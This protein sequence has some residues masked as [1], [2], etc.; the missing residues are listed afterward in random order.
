M[1]VTDMRGNPE[2]M[3]RH[4]EA[5]EEIVEFNTS[6][7]AAYYAKKALAQAYDF[8]QTAAAGFTAGYVF[9]GG[10]IDAALQYTEYAAVFWVGYKALIE[11]PL[12]LKSKE[13]SK[14]MLSELEKEAFKARLLKS[15]G[16]F[17]K[18]DAKN[19]ISEEHSPANETNQ[20]S[21]DTKNSYWA[22][23]ETAK[24][25]LYRLGANVLGAAAATWFVSLLLDGGVNVVD[26]IGPNVL[27]KGIEG[28]HYAMQ[29]APQL[30]PYLTGHAHVG[31]FNQIQMM[32]I[33]AFDG[34]LTTAKQY[35]A[36]NYEII[37]AKIKAGRD[38]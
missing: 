34:V 12:S 28:I 37:K 1:E 31:D 23:L 24:R 15:K 2:V 11:L 9:S 36:G 13:K 30:G 29:Q 17:N 38:N 33:G 14:V 18:Y 35:V 21:N 10:N 3:N 19:G 26:W 6:H 8:A 25:P 20:I 22:N 16:K 27:Q 5:L 32:G 4:T 7:K